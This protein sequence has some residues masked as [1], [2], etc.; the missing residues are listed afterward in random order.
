M[1]H[2]TKD[3]MN[4]LPARTSAHSVDRLPARARLGWSRVILGAALSVL[5]LSLSGQRASAET[6]SGIWPPGQIGTTV[7]NITGPANGQQTSF[8]GYVAGPYNY[9]LLPMTVDL[10]GV[11]TATS[12]TT[13]VVNTTWVLNGIFSPHPVAPTT[14]LGDLIV[15]VLSL[16]GTPKTGTFTG[17]NLVAGQQYSVLVAFNTGSTSGDLSTF[18]IN[19]PGC[20]AIGNNTCAPRIPTLSPVMMVLLVLAMGVLGMWKFPQL[21]NARS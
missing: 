15:A 21:R 8:T 18:T 13:N 1:N 20:V 6:V 14:P 12:S 11:Y 16:N 5:L 9:I 2:P 10:S 7:T 17:I 4:T 19:G 3:T